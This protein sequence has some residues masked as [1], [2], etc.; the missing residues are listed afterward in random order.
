M[1]AKVTTT[2]T[3]IHLP[4][5]TTVNIRVNG[6]N[7]N[8]MIPSESSGPSQTDFLRGRKLPPRALGDSYGLTESTD[9]S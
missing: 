5:G 3:C 7:I 2:A 8:E 9:P 4:S 1:P 6:A